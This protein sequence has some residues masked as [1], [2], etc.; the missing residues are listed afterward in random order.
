M[1]KL[2]IRQG[3]ALSV[4]SDQWAPIIRALGSPTITRETDV[5]YDSATQQWTAT[6]RATGQVIATGQ[7]RAE[8]IQ[9]EVKF[10]EENV[11]Q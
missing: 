3:E 1:P 4:Y 5:E 11:I 7:K 6:L 10:L 8:V 2:V 9:Q